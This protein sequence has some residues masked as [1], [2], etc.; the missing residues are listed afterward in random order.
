[1][2]RAYENVID[3]VKSGDSGAL[4]EMS[5]NEFH[6]LFEAHALRLNTVHREIEKKENRLDAKKLRKA[7]LM[8]GLR[9]PVEGKDVFRAL[10]DLNGIEMGPAVES[11]LMVDEITIEK[12]RATLRT[13][14]GESFSFQRGGEGTW[15]TLL[16]ERAYDLWTE[17]ATFESNLTKVEAALSVQG[18]SGDVKGG[19]LGD[20]R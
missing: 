9:F 10:V 18:G 13:L 16:P 17:R 4:Y 11:G 2:I 6:R 3:G 8:T 7:L 5:R 20:G 1:M 12:D 19:V 14:G 15:R